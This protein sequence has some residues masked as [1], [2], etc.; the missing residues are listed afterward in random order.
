MRTK[1][2][3]SWLVVATLVIALAPWQLVRAQAAADEHIHGGRVVF[4]IDRDAR[5]DAGEHADAVVA[6]MGSAIAAGEVNEAVVALFGDARTTA[7][8]GAAVVALFGNARA[9]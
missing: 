8:V 6:I 1:I 7:R 4:A 2:V 5:L 9:A 3:Q